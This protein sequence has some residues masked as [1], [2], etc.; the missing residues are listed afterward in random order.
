[1]AASE[2]EEGILERGMSRRYLIQ[3]AVGNDPTLVDDDDVVDCLRC[4]SHEV[5][6]QQHGVSS[7]GVATKESPDRADPLGIETIDRLIEHEE[8]GLA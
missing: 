8:T 2:R 5:A 3:G 1:M 7:V 6:G 4:L